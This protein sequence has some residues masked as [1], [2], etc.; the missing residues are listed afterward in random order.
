MLIFSRDYAIFD[1]SLKVATKGEYSSVSNDYPTTLSIGPSFFESYQT[2][3]GAKF[4]HGFNLAKNST[5]ATQALVDSI[6]IACK[7]LSQDNFL[8][9][10]MGNEPDLFK[11]SAQGIVRPKS[12]T[13]ADY[14]KEWN[15][16]ISTVKSVLKS[17][18]G[19]EWISDAK[20]KWL[21]PSFAGTGN[22]LNA[23][24]AWNAGLG[25]SGVIGKF[26]SH[27]YCTHVSLSVAQDTD[28]RQLHWRC[29]TT[30]RYAGRNPH[31]PWQDSFQCI[32]S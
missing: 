30:R 19:D 5:T 2:W 9:W 3:P 7:A 16:R 11:T 22:S 4:S 21:A 31:E 10:E 32:R 28:E 26:S 8:Y 18:C 29:H 15:D 1:S 23:V 12:W 20:F 6:P 25:K 24:K 13:E 17:K 14:V 27:K